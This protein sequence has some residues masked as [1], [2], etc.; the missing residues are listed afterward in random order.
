MQCPEGLHLWFCPLYF[1]KDLA[2]DAE[3]MLMKCMDR[4]AEPGP[5]TSPQTMGMAKNYK[6]KFNRDRIRSCT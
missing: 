3:A 5:Q 4:I 2:Q 6:A 1:I